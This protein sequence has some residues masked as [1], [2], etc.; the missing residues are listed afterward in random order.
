MKVNIIITRMGMGNYHVAIYRSRGR[1][2]YRSYYD[3]KAHDVVEKLGIPE[4]R[5]ESI[6]ARVDADRYYFLADFDLTKERAEALG[7]R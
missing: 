7:L 2:D 1:H 6:L 4:H 3:W 5:G